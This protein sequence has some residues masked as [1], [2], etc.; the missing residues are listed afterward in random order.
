MN[1]VQLDIKVGAN[2]SLEV[3]WGYGSG[4]CSHTRATVAS[5][6]LSAETPIQ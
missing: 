4:N 1:S 5:I 3:D 6:T 2:E